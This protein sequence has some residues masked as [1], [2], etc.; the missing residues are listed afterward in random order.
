[1]NTR[2]GLSIVISHYSTL[3]NY[4]P[5]WLVAVGWGVPQ[6]LKKLTLALP[7]SA[8]AHAAGGRGMSDERRYF[9]W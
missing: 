3:E 8:S 7:T 5:W 4:G 6:S 1:M 9:R 2:V